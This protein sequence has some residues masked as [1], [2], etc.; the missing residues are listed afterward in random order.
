M[1]KNRK[2]RKSRARYVVLGILVL[3]LVVA[4]TVTVTNWDNI[5]AGYA[6]LTSDPE[7]IQAEQEQRK[8]EL[9]QSL[10]I[11]DGFTED[12]MTEAQEV[13]ASILPE[14]LAEFLPGGS[15]SSQNGGD[16]VSGDGTVIADGNGGTTA[17]TN[18]YSGTNVATGETGTSDGSGSSVSGENGSSSAGNSNNSS[19]GSGNSGT[20]SGSTCS[21]RSTD[22]ITRQYTAQLYALEGT[23]QGKINSITSSAKAEYAALPADQ[24]TSSQKT[25]IISS[26]L[27]QAEALEDS[28]DAT[29]ETILANMESELK[30]AGGDT[31]AVSQLRDYYESEKASKKSAAIAA[32]RAG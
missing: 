31:A 28:C 5:Q 25:A 13:L 16:T 29:V 15:S 14:S 27:D 2:K 8:A 12:E 3:L 30:A 17:G 7:E 18:G 21:G 23:L 19:S 24:R 22:A 11:G 10:G 20:V 9:E 4:G 32:M 6:G 26:A 1:A